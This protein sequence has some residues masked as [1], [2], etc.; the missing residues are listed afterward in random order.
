[1]WRSNAATI[2]LVGEVLE[3]M[4]RMP[5]SHDQSVLRKM[6]IGCPM[7]W[8]GENLVVDLAPLGMPGATLRV[9]HLDGLL[10]VNT[11][12]AFTHGFEKW[13]AAAIQGGVRAPIVVHFFH[14][15][16]Y[17]EKISMMKA[18]RLWHLEG[19]FDRCAKRRPKG[20]DWPWWNPASR[21]R[22]PKFAI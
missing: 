21:A 5:K 16:G 20:T 17:G 18:T 4:L 13:R 8:E 12:G 10:A 1:M 6:T 22:L 9:R 19:P 2:A 14:L 11:G 15:G 7:S 3:R